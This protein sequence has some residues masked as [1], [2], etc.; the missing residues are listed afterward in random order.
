MLLL[1]VQ[2]NQYWRPLHSQDITLSIFILR[3]LFLHLQVVFSVCLR[4]LGDKVLLHQIGDHHRLQQTQQHQ[5]KDHDAVGGCVEEN[6][7]T[8]YCNGVFTRRDAKT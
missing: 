4:L 8:T 7:S 6:M 1:R 3:I 5:T 2:F